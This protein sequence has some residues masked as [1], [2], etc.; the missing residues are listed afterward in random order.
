MRFTG[1]QMLQNIPAL[2]GFGGAFIISGRVLVKRFK[3]NCIKCRYLRTKFIDVEIGA[4]SSHNLSVAP[5]CYVSQNDMFGPF[6]ALDS[7]TK[8]KTIK[9]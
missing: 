2:R 7:Y 8:R 3:L 4:I 5:A 6:K 1:I 9:V